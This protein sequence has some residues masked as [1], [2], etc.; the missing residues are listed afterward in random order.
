MR[1]F[2]TTAF[3]GA[4]NASVDLGRVL[5]ALS[6]VAFLSFELVALCRGA[7]FDSMSFAGALSTL[8][9]GHG[10]SLR[11]KGETEPEAK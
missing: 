1:H 9:I 3:T 10:A 6:T 8:A 5:W 2:L 11:L 4:D 7:T